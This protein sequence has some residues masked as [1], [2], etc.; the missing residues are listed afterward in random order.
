MSSA[1]PGLPDDGASAIPIDRLTGRG[2]RQDARVALSTLTART[3]AR[4]KCCHVISFGWFGSGGALDRVLSLAVTVGLDSLCPVRVRPIARNP[5]YGW[6]RF[7][8]MVCST[9]SAAIVWRES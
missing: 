5:G 9:D 6:G 3:H 8:T 7:L 1:R 4:T 2:A